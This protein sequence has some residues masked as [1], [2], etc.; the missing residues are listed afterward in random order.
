[1]HKKSPRM[2]T[3]WPVV[4]M[5]KKAAAN[6]FARWAIYATQQRGHGQKSIRSSQEQP[7]E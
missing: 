4:E 3:L 1:M 5:R 6:L 2:N 7:E